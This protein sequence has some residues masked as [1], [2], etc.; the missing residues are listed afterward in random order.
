MSKTY[1]RS[2]Q[3]RNKLSKK[4]GGGPHSSGHKKV[5][6]SS[7]I[8]RKIKGRASFFEH[9]KVFNPKLNNKPTTY[10]RKGPNTIFTIPTT[11]GLTK[12]TVDTKLDEEEQHKAFAIFNDKFRTIQDFFINKLHSNMLGSDQGHNGQWMCVTAGAGN[13]RPSGPHAGSWTMLPK[14]VEECSTVNDDD[15]VNSVEGKRVISSEN[16]AGIF[17]LPENYEL[18]ILVPPGTPVIM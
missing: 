9:D 2:R 11:A 15:F 7:I 13:W 18:M 5:R 3:R 14:E 1:R 10:T 17:W 8:G 6:I 4:R 16:E 12:F